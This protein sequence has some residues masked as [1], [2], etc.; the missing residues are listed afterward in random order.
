MILESN[1]MM[2]FAIQFNNLHLF[3]FTTLEDI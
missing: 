1:N 2:L 3:G